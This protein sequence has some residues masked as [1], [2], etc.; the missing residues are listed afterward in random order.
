MMLVF[1]RFAIPVVII[2]TNFLFSTFLLE[3]QESATAALEVTSTR[4]N[5]L[6]T[7]SE[8]TTSPDEVLSQTDG[9]A[10]PE[11]SG[12]SLKD[13]L[14]SAYESL[15]SIAEVGSQM[16]SSTQE[17]VSNVSDWF[18][19]ISVS[20]RMAQLKAS[21]AEATSHIVNLIV[22]FVLQTIIFPLGFLWLFVEALKA[23]A[24]R[25]ISALGVG[26]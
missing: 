26:S 14:V 17:Y 13:T 11:P 25:S 10:P 18:G 16:K 21:A 8:D 1:V 15:P 7:Q 24:T 9:Q 12:D 4:L 20:T 5:K 6:N 2:C 23:A 22:I 3:D 19:S